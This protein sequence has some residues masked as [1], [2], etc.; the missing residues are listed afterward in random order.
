MQKRIFTAILG[1]PLLIAVIKL[2]S[3]PLLMGVILLSSI[4]L[5]EIYNT[6]ETK[7]ENQINVNLEIGLNILLLII[8]NLNSEFIFPYI[9]FLFMF[10][11]SY[12]LFTKN[13]SFKNALL[14]FIGIFYIGFM[15][16]HILLFDTL[17]YGEYLIWLVFIV[18]FSTDTFAYFTGIYLGNKKLCPNISPKKTIEGSV[19]GIF[20][21]LFTCILYGI[22]LNKVQNINISMIHFMIIGFFASIISQFG[23]LTASL[24]KR[25]YGIKDFGKIFPGH[26]G[27]LDRFDSIIFVTPTIYYY[28]INFIT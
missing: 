2:G 27:I 1:I 11:F 13:P 3:I 28:I 18:A 6:F 23:D 9:I 7:K 16:G 5:K 24:I 12:Q 26:G 17:I 25:N 4:G 21:S 22:Y 8:M 10:H 19:G 20:G 14:G 15:L